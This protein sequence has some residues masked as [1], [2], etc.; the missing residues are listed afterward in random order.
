MCKEAYTETPSRR[1]SDAVEQELEGRGHRVQS[2][3]PF[4]LG[5]IGMG[6][7]CEYAKGTTTHAAGIDPV[8]GVRRAASDPR[9]FGHAVGTR[10]DTKRLTTNP[11]DLTGL[12]AVAQAP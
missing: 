11:G 3:D 6:P 7:G 10:S 5:C 4:A 2:S 1:F 12:A 8:S 9:P